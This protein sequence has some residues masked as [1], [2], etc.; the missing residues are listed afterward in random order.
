MSI[1]LS[2]LTNEELF[3]MVDSLN[4]STI[5]DNALIRAATR[6]I[7]DTDNETL[8]QLISMATPIATELAK[9]LKKEL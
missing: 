8:V 2:N 4:M 3:D 6:K 5:P 7:Y 1:D 9:R